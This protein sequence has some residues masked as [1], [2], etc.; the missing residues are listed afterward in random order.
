MPLENYEEDWEDN[1]EW[2]QEADTA[3]ME[4]T[5]SFICNRKHVFIISFIFDND[6]TYHAVEIYSTNSL[7]GGLNTLFGTP[8]LEEVNSSDDSPE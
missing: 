7:E 2:I 1:H 3:E 5:I 8:A 6:C 4:L